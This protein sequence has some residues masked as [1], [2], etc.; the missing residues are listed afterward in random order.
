MLS[1]IVLL[2]TERDKT[3]R[4]AEALADTEG[5]SEVYSVAGR[6]DLVAI[7]RASDND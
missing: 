5:V 1:A 4:V 3:K 2:T 7:V 6:F